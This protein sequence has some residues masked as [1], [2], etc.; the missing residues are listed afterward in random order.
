VDDAWI[1]ATALEHSLP[2][3]THHRAD[4]VGIPGLTIISAMP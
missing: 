1:S 3:V 4:F 2:L